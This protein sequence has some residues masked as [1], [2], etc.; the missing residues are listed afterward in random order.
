MVVA[1]AMTESFAVVV[2]LVLVT[3]ASGFPGQTSP[4]HAGQASLIANDAE[5]S[6]EA[7]RGIGFT[8]PQVAENPE[9]HALAGVRAS[10]SRV[11]K[12]CPLYTIMLV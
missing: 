8:I 1:V 11:Q 4:A 2:V 10:F 12:N 3:V 7:A 5:L 6:E 9:L